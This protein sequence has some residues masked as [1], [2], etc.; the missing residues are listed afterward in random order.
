MLYTLTEPKFK[1]GDIVEVNG[2]L[3]IM[4]SWPPTNE[5]PFVTT[6][7][8]NEADPIRYASGWAGPIDNAFHSV[9]KQ[10]EVVMVEAA[11]EPRST[12]ADISASDKDLATALAVADAVVE[13][14][15]E[16]DTKKA[17][18]GV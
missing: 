6:Y 1:Q 4:Q 7:R 5:G 16:A 2:E 15:W 3:C 12:A 11:G 13:A 10:D 14:G 8:T 17:V 18:A 9:H